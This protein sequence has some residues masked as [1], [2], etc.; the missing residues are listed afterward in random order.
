MKFSPIFRRFV[1]Q[2]PISAMS[3]ALMERAHGGEQMDRWFDQHAD[4]QYTNTLLFSTVFDIMSFVVCGMDK[5]VHAACQ[6]FKGDI[7]VSVKSF[8]NKLNE[9]EPAT[10]AELVRYAAVQ[11]TPIIQK[12]GGAIKPL[13]PGFRVKMLDGNC[14]EAADHR[15][16]ELRDILRN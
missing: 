14:I 12:L 8:Y 3:R 16:K 6:A 7:G 15:I 10:S 9:L 5:A 11:A 1:D 4:K 2:S 13:L